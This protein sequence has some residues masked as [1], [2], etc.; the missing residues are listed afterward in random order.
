MKAPSHALNSSFH[1]LNRLWVQPPRCQQS[2]QQPTSLVTAAHG[3]LVALQ[4]P[5]WGSWWELSYVPPVDMVKEE[6]ACAE[7]TPPDWME[8]GLKQAQLHTGVKQAGAFSWTR[9]RP[10]PPGHG[11]AARRAP[12]A[13][14]K[15]EQSVAEFHFPVSTQ[16]S[17][18]ATAWRLFGQKKK[19]EKREL[20]LH[21]ETKKAADGNQ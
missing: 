6:L 9:T 13:T 12:G 15:A 5:F 3:D 11:E 7:E 19:K 20:G 4:C 1:Q 8:T 10:R 21:G 16:R 18:G 2:S 17:A 14:G